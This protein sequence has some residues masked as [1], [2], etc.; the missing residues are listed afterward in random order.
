MRSGYTKTKLVFAVAFTAVI[1]AAIYAQVSPIEKIKEGQD[2]KRALFAKSIIAGIDSF[3]NINKRLPW[4]DDLA[5]EKA[6]SPLA[7]VPIS[8]PAVGI[9]RDLECK[10]KGELGDL[11]PALYPVPDLKGDLYIGR[12]DHL[13]DPVFVCF[14]PESES[15]R[16]KTGELYKVDL[17]SNLPI[18]ESMRACPESVNWQED[19][20]YYC[21][22]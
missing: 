11:R 17:K 22:K 10:V 6:L 20:C 16:R 2:E 18:S 12:G 21:T 7:F 13:N 4:T 3:Y 19:V 1:F 5:S 15:L 8:D 14:L 9:C